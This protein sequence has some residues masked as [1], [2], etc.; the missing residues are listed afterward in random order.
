MTDEE[1]SDEA[2]EHYIKECPF[3]VDVEEMFGQVV[4][5]DLVPDEDGPDELKASIVVNGTIFSGT[6]D[7]VSEAVK[8]MVESLHEEYSS[9][10]CELALIRKRMTEKEG[11]K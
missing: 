10:A 2:Y 8:E 3:I 1:A 7:T 9:V 11:V 6:G 4:D 5:I